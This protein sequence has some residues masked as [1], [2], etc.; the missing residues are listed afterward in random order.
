MLQQ[1][2]LFASAVSKHNKA[3]LILPTPKLLIQI[4]L[5]HPQ[6][7]KQFVSIETLKTTYRRR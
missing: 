4:C 2:L 1:I 3:V 5:F 7:P 6:N